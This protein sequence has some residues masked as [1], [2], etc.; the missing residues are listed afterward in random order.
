MCA[1]NTSLLVLAMVFLSVTSQA[2]LAAAEGNT[3]IGRYLTV[4][5]KPKEAQLNLLA[6]TIQVRFPQTIQT[7]GEAAHYI[8]RFSGYSLLP[9][10]QISHAL[11]TT[12]A[13]PLPAI[14]RDFGPMSLKEALTTLIGPAFYLK[15]D[16]LNRTVDF[17]VKPLY[18]RLASDSTDTDD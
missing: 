3:P 5:N 13:K 15:Q 10:D 1:Q 17:R 11:K 8:L 6:Q 2:V 9:D 7:V 12:L 4:E 16:P 14:D 18:A